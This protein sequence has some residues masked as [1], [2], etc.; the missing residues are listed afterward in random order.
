MHLDKYSFYQNY[1]EVPREALFTEWKET[2]AFAIETQAIWSLA[3]HKE[4]DWYFGN[5]IE[6]QAT[7]KWKGYIEW[8]GGISLGFS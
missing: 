2:N 8:E 3:E 5:Y 1:E 4:G 7:I 6:W